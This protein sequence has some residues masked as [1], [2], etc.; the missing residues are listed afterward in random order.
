[1]ECSSYEQKNKNDNS[2]E[3]GNFVKGNKIWSLNKYRSNRVKHEQKTKKA[4]T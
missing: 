3:K 4:S 1:M 2:V